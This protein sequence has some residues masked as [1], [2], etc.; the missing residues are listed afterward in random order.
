MIR[1]EATVTCETKPKWSPEPRF[2]N[3]KPLEKPCLFNIVSDPCEMENLAEKLVLKLG[4][5]SQFYFNEIS[6][7]SD[8]RKLQN[9][10]KVKLQLSME[11]LFVQVISLGIQGLI[12]DF[13]ITHGIIL[14]IIV[15]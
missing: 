5:I 8:F 9:F 13:G 6:T 10:F 12:Q 7:L 4:F 15:L 3:C 2:S 11:R 14:E 1:K